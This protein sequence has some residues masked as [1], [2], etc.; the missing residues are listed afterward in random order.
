MDAVN[1]DVEFVCYDLEGD[2]VLGKL[3][4]DGGSHGSPE[5]G[6]HEVM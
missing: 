4:V 5:V 6:G 1:A 2:H 3:D